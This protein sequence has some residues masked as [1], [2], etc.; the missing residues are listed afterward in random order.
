MHRVR[1]FLL[2]AILIT[3]GIHDQDAAKVTKY[4]E[5]DE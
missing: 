3:E 2:K 5:V 1:S 4:L